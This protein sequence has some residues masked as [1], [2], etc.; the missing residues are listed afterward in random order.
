MTTGDV[1]DRGE[2]GCAALLTMTVVS[3]AI[4]LRGGGDGSLTPCPG[5]GMAP[6]G[7]MG[8]QFGGKNWYPGGGA[9]TGGVGDRA[10]PDLGMTDCWMSVCL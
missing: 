6:T 1:V 2:H 4:A 10:V 5:A 8:M 3:E 9:I 7:T